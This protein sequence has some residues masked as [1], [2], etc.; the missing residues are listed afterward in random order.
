VSKT[1]AIPIAV[2][3]LMIVCIVGQACQT[4]N[5]VVPET[6]AEPAQTTGP[7]NPAPNPSTS[8]PTTQASGTDDKISVDELKQELESGNTMVIVDVRPRALFDISHIDGAIS[9]PLDEMPARYQEIPQER[10]IIVYAACA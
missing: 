1:F 3:C 6:T 4:T 7:T 8:P 10:E 2:V 9:I 5:T